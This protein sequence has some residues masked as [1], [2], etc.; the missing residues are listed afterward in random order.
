MTI[1]NNLIG[2]TVASVEICDREVLITF[3]DHSEIAMTVTASEKI[4]AIKINPIPDDLSIPEW[5][6]RA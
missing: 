6:K 1:G 4:A 5:L 3:T 2:K